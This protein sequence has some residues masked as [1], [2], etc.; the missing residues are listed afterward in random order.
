MNRHCDSRPRKPAQRLK[1]GVFDHRSGARAAL[2]VE[3][4][5]VSIT[6]PLG[7]STQHGRAHQRADGGVIRRVLPVFRLV[8]EGGD[9]EDGEAEEK[10]EHEQH[11]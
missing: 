9:D 10:A 11:I 2:E 4:S 3:S 6:Q 1:P 7:S 5:S 8:D